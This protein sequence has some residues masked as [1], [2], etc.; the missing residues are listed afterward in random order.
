[1]STGDHLSA[2]LTRMLIK[3]M[4][5]VTNDGRDSE[6]VKILEEFFNFNS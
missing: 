3:Q 1:M 2:K 6:K 4:K 5:E